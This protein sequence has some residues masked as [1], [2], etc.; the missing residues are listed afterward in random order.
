MKY[1][2]GLNVRNAKYGEKQN[3][4]LN[5]TKSFYVRVSIEIAIRNKKS[6]KTTSLFDIIIFKFD[7]LYFLSTYSLIYS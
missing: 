6:E 5:K 7:S 3:V 4:K 2:T 1:K